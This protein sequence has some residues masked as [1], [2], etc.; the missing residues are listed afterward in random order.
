MASKIL[1]TISFSC[2]SC[3]PYIFLGVKNLENENDFMH[4]FG[5]G[6]SGIN[7]DRIKGMDSGVVIA[8]NTIMII[9]A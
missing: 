9:Q 6:C 8:Y 5:Y 7:F 3:I 4:S 1:N 2:D